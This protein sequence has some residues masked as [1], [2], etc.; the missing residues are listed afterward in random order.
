M[1]RHLGLT[2]YLMLLSRP[3]KETT[4]AATPDYQFC[5]PIVSYSFLDSLVF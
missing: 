1:L 3:F 2:T 5:A 4:A